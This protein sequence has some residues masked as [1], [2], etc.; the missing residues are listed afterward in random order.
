MH[1]E[2][3]YV[4]GYDFSDVSDLALFR[5]F[6]EAGH[7]PHAKVDVVWVT[8][9]GSAYLMGFGLD[10]MDIA[11]RPASLQRRALWQAAHDAYRSWSKDHVAHIEIT[12][13]V[14]VGVPAEEL[15]DFAKEHEA[16]LLIMGMH[17]H[18]F[19]HRL[20]HQSV[21]EQVVRASPFEVLVVQP[22]DMVAQPSET[23]PVPS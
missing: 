7:D 11:M 4:V 3:C 2:N 20:F 15:I 1:Q 13:H 12:T 21:T 22:K 16:K 17:H 6:D 8:T 19:F 10:A 9:P 23:I 5:A 14:K 18:S